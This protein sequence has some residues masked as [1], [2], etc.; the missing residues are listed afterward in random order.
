MIDGPIELNAASDGS[1]LRTKAQ[2]R[3][4]G[5]WQVCLKIRKAYANVE[6]IKPGLQQSKGD[7][8]EVSKASPRAYLVA[9]SMLSMISRRGS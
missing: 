5:G 7:D 1:E 8:L 2:N 4:R 9:F 6:P 3:S